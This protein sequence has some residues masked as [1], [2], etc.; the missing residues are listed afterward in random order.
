MK[1]WTKEEDRI[2]EKFYPTMGTKIIRHFEGRTIDSVEHRARRLHVK[3]IPTGEGPTGFLDIESNGLQGDFNYMLTWAIKTANKEEIFY[4][5]ISAED[6]LS[7]E[8]DKRITQE[9]IDTMQ[10]YKRIY[11]Y[12]GTMFD[13]P[14]ARARAL[15]HKLT[16]VPYGI[17]EHKDIY[18]L[19]RRVL[20]IHRKRLETVCDLLGIKGKT[21][22]DP[23]LWMMAN[24]GDKRAIK[25]ILE[26][27]IADVKILEL[28]YRKLQP[29]E[30]RTRR[31]I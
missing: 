14:F 30:G 27:N 2:L 16:F 19:A 4:G 24:S 28:A 22:I 21:H 7:G 18:Y 20:R 12:Y 11:T 26:H 8:F 6:I 25:Y 13:I 17:I 15:A 23:K 1:K 31:F 5:A 29:Y 3:F 9:L 10:K